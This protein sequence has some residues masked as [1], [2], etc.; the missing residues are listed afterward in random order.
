MSAAATQR[1]REMDGGREE[2]KGEIDDI[3]KVK[4]ATKRSIG[5]TVRE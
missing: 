5:T 2:R 3:N 1:E 4:C